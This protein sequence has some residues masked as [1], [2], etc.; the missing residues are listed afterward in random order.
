MEGLSKNTFNII[1][2]TVLAISLTRQYEVLGKQINPVLNILEGGLLVFLIYNAYNYPNID[3]Q[4]LLIRWLII[5]ILAV[6]FMAYLFYIK[7]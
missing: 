3:K 1:I 7:K 4:R 6:I 5:A 2:L